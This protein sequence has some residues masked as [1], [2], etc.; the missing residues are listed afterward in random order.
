MPRT[1]EL[2]ELRQPVSHSRMLNMQTPMSSGVGLLGHHVKTT[3]TVSNKRWTPV[4][5]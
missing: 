4:R 3:S 5:S 2:D 1:L